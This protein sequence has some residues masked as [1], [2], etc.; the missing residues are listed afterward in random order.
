MGLVTGALSDTV[1]QTTVPYLRR[2]GVAVHRA[3]VHEEAPDDALADVDPRVVPLAVDVP[4]RGEF[5]VGEPYEDSGP[6]WH[7]WGAAARSAAG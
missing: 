3:V 7:D 1:E 5:A 4:G 6:S 2:L